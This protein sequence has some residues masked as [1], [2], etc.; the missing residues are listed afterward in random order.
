[1]LSLLATLYTALLSCQ[2]MAK[3]KVKAVDPQ[4]QPVKSVVIEKSPNDDRTYTAIVLPNQLQ[5]VLVSD[6]TLESSAASLTVGVGS[7]QD[8]KTQPGLAHYLEHM[9]FLGT[10][11][12]PIPDSFFE[13]VQTNA[14]TTN[15]FTT[16]EK[17]NFHFQLHTEKFDEAL[18][19]FSDYFKAPTF[20]PQFADKE[21]NAV[22]SEWSMNRSQDS[23]ILHA[24]EGLT[25]NPNNPHANFNIGNLES[26]ADKENS[27]LQA[28][29]KAFYS[30]YYSAN[31]M[32]LTLVGKQSIPELKELAEKYFSPII[33][34]NIFIPKISVP[35]L[36]QAEM[37]KIIQYRSQ[38]DL[39]KIYLDFPIKNNKHLWRV[40]PNEFVNNL[41]TSEEVGTLCE[42]LRAVGLANNVTAY[43]NP[44]EYGD[45]GYLRIEADVTTTGLKN[46]D[47][48]IASVFS[49]IELIK[50]QGVKELYFRELKAMRMKDFENS[51]K[52]DPLS[53]A[54][55]IAME[56]FD[57]PLENLLNADFTYDYFDT[58]AINNLLQQ[59]Q[60]E[61]VRIWYISKDQMVDK[62]IP[63]FEGKYA[64]RDISAEEQLRWVGAANSLTFNLPSINTLFTD[65]PADI[66]E[67]LYVKPHQVVSQKGVEAFLAQPQYYREDKGF[68]SV[69]MNVSFA[70]KSPK[71][72]VLAN[73]LSSIYKNQ[74]TTIIDRAERASLG[75]AIV[76]SGTYSQSVSISGYTSKHEE[77]LEQLLAGFVNL[78]ITEKDFS[79][80]LTK[81]KQLKNSTKSSAPFKQALNHTK[82]LLSDTPWTDE[83]LLMAAT[84]LRIKDVESYHKAV[85]ADSLVRMFVF[86]NYTEAAVKRMALA[87]VKQLP[88][89][90]LPA[91][92]TLTKF[93]TP[94][95]SKPLTY[96]NTV[97][98]EDSVLVD[99]YIGSDRSDDE[100]AQFIVLNAIFHNAFFSQLRT[101]E[102][103]GY[104]VGSASFPVKDYP[105]F[106]MYV[107]STTMD[108]VG[109]KARMDRFRSEFLTQLN[110]V[111]PAH[112]ERFKKSEIANVL[113]KPTDFYDEAKRFPAD[114]WAGYYDFD[115]RWRYLVALEKVNKEN[116][117]ALYQK[118]LLDKKSMHMLVQLKGTAHASKPFAKP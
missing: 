100:K 109:I 64:I 25:A 68:L 93:I 52:L 42:Q 83:E 18:D 11:K 63:Y 5:V 2:P 10:E 60:P 112:I 30:H 36:T 111:D 48:I 35:G 92:R 22:N 28:E 26:L 32:R 87:A 82:R 94:R 62:T 95:V 108:L 39:K 69:E 99:A 56:Q 24:L 70:K 20:D 73:L 38:K 79:E 110:A 114:F 101:N 106:A 105:G 61:N 49:Y 74:N 14:G 85:K 96:Q 75:I 88:S 29:L 86:G 47:R 44:N 98:Q 43:I 89:E 76:P 23:W 21:R 1:M 37:G 55:H 8:P 7:A 80:A 3:Q 84:K 81:Y 57:T 67:S 6:P 78:K 102:Q 16:F 66:V 107:Q 54:I 103:L 90:R 17:T 59:L 104:V 53:Q 46:P 115:A 19:R 9:L 45:D 34:K 27:N 72:I 50:Q 51:T 41:I 13:F 118:I 40:K 31:N 15:A 113:Q 4:V 97:E 116:L 33:N 71:N 12:Y 65:K 91:Q 58:H 77:L 117:L